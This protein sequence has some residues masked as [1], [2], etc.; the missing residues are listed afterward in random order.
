MK[1]IIQLTTLFFIYC[2]VF[3][4]V[5]YTSTNKN[6]GVYLYTRPTGR[7]L[8]G[9]INLGYSN[10]GVKGSFAINYRVRNVL[11]GVGYYKSHICYDH[12]QK[13]DCFLDTEDS[14]NHKTVKYI[15]VFSGFIL[16]GKLSPSLSFGISWI[17]FTYLTAKPIEHNVTL[18]RIWQ[19]I[20]GSDYTKERLSLRTI[21]TIGIPVGINLHFKPKHFAGIDAALNTNVNLHSVIV[22]GGIGIHLGRIIRR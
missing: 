12:Y 21:N 19:T 13:H 22:S 18:P 11:Y 4:Q 14:Q 2:P 10:N 3:S 15:S 6:S 7:S 1:A 9:E 20:V 5:K 16:P 17:K 8:W